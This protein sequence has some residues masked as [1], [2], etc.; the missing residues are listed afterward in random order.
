[1]SVIPL[2]KPL[3]VSLLVLRLLELWSV[4][5][6]LEMPLVMCRWNTTQT[7]CAQGDPD[8]HRGHGVSELRYAARY[9]EPARSQRTASPQARPGL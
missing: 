4:L 3:L 1:M 8:K 6:L 9:A 5:R 2:V 7:R